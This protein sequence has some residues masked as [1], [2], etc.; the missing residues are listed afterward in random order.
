MHD[1]P[2]VASSDGIGLDRDMLIDFVRCFSMDNDDDEAGRWG[3]QM[4]QANEV[5]STNHVGLAA[6]NPNIS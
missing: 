1:F 3:R 5:G 6:A 2:A 4:R